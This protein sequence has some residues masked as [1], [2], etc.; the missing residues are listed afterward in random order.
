MI[1][2]KRYH[3]FLYIGLAKFVYI[4]YKFLSNGKLCSGNYHCCVQITKQTYTIES[5]IVWPCT[6]TDYKVN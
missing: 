4:L 6:T 1:I 3:L 5:I 2:R